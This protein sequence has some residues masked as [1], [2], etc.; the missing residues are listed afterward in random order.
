MKK[1]IVTFLF[2]LT[3]GALSSENAFAST[4]FDNE[5]NRLSEEYNIEL[6]NLETTPTINSTFLEFEDLKEFE[7][8]LKENET[9]DTTILH[10]EI[11]IDKPDTMSLERNISSRKTF[12]SSFSDQW[13]SPING[14]VTGLLSWKN[15]SYDYTYKEGAN[16]PQFVS[17]SNI[18]SWQT[19]YHD[20]KWTQNKYGGSYKIIKAV[21]TDDSVEVTA[22]GLYTL[23]VVIASQPIGYSWNGEWVR[24]MQ[25]KYK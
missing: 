2:L 18:D 12:S 13:Y 9:N 7:N 15:M 6:V 19:G 22:K 4:N 25:L 23:G 5:L 8:Y 1:A 20:V 17:V 21:Y 24:T 11:L 3:F 10:D 16:S 14:F